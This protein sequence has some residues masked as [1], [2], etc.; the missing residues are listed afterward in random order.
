[1]PQFTAPACTSTE[2][3]RTSLSPTRCREGPTSACR[4]WRKG[5]SSDT[6]VLQEDSPPALQGIG[7]K[8][9][10]DNVRLLRRVPGEGLRLCSSLETKGEFDHS[11]SVQLPRQLPELY[12]MVHRL[13]RGRGLREDRVLLLPYCQYNVRFFTT[14]NILFVL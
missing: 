13:G 9:Q 10:R 8:S 6:R 14:R 5:S 12:A 2:R 4:R 7:L 11:A 3:G 1:M